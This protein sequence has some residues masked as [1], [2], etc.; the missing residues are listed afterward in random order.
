MNGIIDKDLVEQRAWRKICSLKEMC[1]Q[2]RASRNV[3]DD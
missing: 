2:L 1:I 3:Y